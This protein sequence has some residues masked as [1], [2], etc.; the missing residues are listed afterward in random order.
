[1]AHM[2]YSRFQTT[3]VTTNDDEVVEVRPDT[4]SAVE[5]KGMYSDPDI[6]HAAWVPQA[7]KFPNL[8]FSVQFIVGIILAKVAL[9]LLPQ[10]DSGEADIATSSLLRQG[11]SISI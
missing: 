11:N 2:S 8:C 6:A 10:K 5:S 9:D 1:M 7:S 4:S 3:F